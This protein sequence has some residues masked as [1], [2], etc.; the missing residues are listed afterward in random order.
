MTKYV[1]HYV[2]IYIYIH[3][4]TNTFINSIIGIQKS[5]LLNIFIMEMRARNVRSLSDMENIEWQMV[6]P[7]NNPTL[8]RMLT[9]STGV[10]TTLD[11]G[12]AVISQKARYLL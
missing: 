9:I 6:R 11:I 10:F 2:C 12:E 3:I 8:A 7:T 5:R 1:S 4:I